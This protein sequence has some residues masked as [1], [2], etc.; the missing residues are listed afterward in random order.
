M[1]HALTLSGSIRRGSYNEKLALFMRGLLEEKGA[2]AEYVDLRD[3]GLPVFNE[4]LEDNPPEA[5][6][7]L[8][9]KFRDADIIFI[10]SPE[11]NGGV[12]PLMKNTIDWITRQRQG[13]FNKAIF[14]LGACSSGKLSG[15][16][17]LSHMRDT[18]TKI[19]ALVA[20]M[21]V[22]VGPSEG[23]FDD[24]GYLVDEFSRKR[25]DTLVQQL[26]SFSKG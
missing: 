9:Q 8:A 18:L 20:P 15:Y 26:M 5:A 12:A 16:Q 21:D 23:A 7:Q 13:A 11:Y 19:N 2:E 4:D 25:A 3:Y 14:G 1:R 10:A 17:A 22:R 6:M 24:Q